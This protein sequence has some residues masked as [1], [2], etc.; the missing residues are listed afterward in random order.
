M[1]SRN[2][3]EATPS[4]VQNEKAGDSVGHGNVAFC[5][6]SPLYVNGEVSPLAS[7]AEEAKLATAEVKAPSNNALSVCKS[8]IAGGVAGGV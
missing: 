8:L 4:R 1:V 2:D 5:Q 3:E 6:R 7:L